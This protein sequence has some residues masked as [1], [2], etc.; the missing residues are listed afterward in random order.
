MLIL[1]ERE[2]ERGGG[3]NV[4]RTQFSCKKSLSQRSAESR[5]FSPGTPVSPLEE[6]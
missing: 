1:S 4:T 6:I 5:R 3:L 2:R